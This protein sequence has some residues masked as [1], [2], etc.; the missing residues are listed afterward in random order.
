MAS[1][2]VLVGTPLSTSSSSSYVQ[3]QAFEVDA[4]IAR[5]YASAVTSAG[6]THGGQRIR[7]NNSDACLAAFTSYFCLNPNI[8]ATYS[9]NG[10]CGIPPPATFAPCLK[11]CTDFQTVCLGLPASLASAACA[12]FAVVGSNTASNANCYCSD[13]SPST[14]SSLVCTAGCS[15]D[16]Q[17]SPASPHRPPPRAG[18]AAALML[19]LASG[20]SIALPLPV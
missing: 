3:A 9:L 1:C 20:L 2:N 10:S 17:C 4:F 18:L 13:S 19:A 7:V 8:L 14:P 12:A 11:R 5:G 6:W 16:S 15:A